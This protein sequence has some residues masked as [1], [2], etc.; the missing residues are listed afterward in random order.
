MNEQLT[1]EQAMAKL[2][3]LLAAIESDQVKVAELSILLKEAEEL[4]S[5]CEAQLRETQKS[6]TPKEAKDLG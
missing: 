4:T 3:S 6:I 1:F 2:E 5:W